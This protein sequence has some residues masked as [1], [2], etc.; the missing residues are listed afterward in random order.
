MDFAPCW[1]WEGDLDFDPSYA[2]DPYSKQI[3]ATKEDF[4][5]YLC[6]PDEETEN[7]YQSLTD[8]NYVK[9]QFNRSERTT[10]SHRGQNR[11]VGTRNKQPFFSKNRKPKT[12]EKVPRP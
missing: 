5:P 12:L 4:D 11:E 10:T 3:G 6:D 8:Q 1:V 2:T 7:D 9:Y